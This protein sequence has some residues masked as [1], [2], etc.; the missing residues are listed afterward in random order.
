L[1]FPLGLLARGII[2]REIQYLG[3]KELFRPPLGWIFRALGGY[4]V[5]RQQSQFMVDRVAEIFKEQN[6]FLLALAP[7]G[8][9]SQVTNWRTGFYHIAVKAGVPIQMIGMDYSRK[10]I[11]IMELFYPIGAVDLDMPIIR[12]RFS[13]IQGKNLV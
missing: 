9:R 4:P 6:S 8:T 10:V 12:D 13:E 11:Q 1:G 3:K 7:E 2:D 5:D